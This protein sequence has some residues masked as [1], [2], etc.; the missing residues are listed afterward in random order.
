MQITKGIVRVDHVGEGASVDKVD[1][2]E[3]SSP[4]P[5]F[6]IGGGEGDTNVYSDSDET[7]KPAVEYKKGSLASKANALAR[8][9]EKGENK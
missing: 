3:V 9:N 4:S 8:Y 6:N 1:T 2:N 5:S 7:E